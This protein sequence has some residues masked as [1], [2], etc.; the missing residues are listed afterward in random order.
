MKHKRQSMWVYKLLIAVL[1]IS[2]TLAVWLFWHSRGQVPALAL[3]GKKMT[4][5]LKDEYNYQQRDPR[6]AEQRLGQR[7]HTGTLGSH[8]CTVSAIA[9][10]LSNLDIPITPGELNQQMSAHGGF[11][12]RGWLVWGEKMANIRLSNT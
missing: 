1:I 7:E 4:Q 12:E 3:G 6:W 8:G 10:A 9:N 5:I 11:N 2:S